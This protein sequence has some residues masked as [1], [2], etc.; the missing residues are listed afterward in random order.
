VEHDENVAKVWLDPVRLHRTAGFRASEL[1]HIQRL[2]EGHQAQL[3]EAWHDYFN[4]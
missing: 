1:R 2:V 4:Y 3:L